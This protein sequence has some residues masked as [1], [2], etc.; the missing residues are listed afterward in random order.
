MGKRRGSVGLLPSIIL[1]SLT[2]GN[3]NK[4][5]KNDDIYNSDTNL[6]KN[7]NIQENVDDKKSHKSLSDILNANEYDL[8]EQERL[9]YYAMKLQK[10]NEIKDK[11]EDII[12]EANELKEKYKEIISKYILKQKQKDL[13][14]NKN[15]KFKNFRKSK[16]K[17]R[18]EE[19]FP[20]ENFEEISSQQR[21]K[22]Q[23]DLIKKY[24]SS[25][26]DDEENSDSNESESDEIKD[27]E[28]KLNRKKK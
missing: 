3:S 21:K 17:I 24:Y 25:F 27:S 6:D 12:G 10:L 20:D 5:K 26:S 14:K 7:I 28:E 23:N 1:E 8:D 9:I 13:T 19:L 18:Y 4:K 11:D 22:K 2:K 16:I 15:K